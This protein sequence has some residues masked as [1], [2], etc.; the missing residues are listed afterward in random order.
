MQED[1][2]KAAI[3]GVGAWGKNIARELSAISNLVAYSSSGSEETTTWASE[4]LPNAEATTV[5][6]ICADASITAV[7]V[8]TPTDTH[9]AIAHELILAGK[10]I[11]IEKP[12]AKTALEAQSIT[13]E[14]A[15]SNLM[16]ATGYIFLYSPVYR[17]LKSLIG[18][19]KIVK[20]ECL[21]QKYGT[22][23]ESV[24]LNLLTHHLAIAIDLL[25]LPRAIKVEKIGDAG[26][27]IKTALTY[28]GVEFL[29]HIDRESQ[30][31]IH[32]FEITLDSGESF[33][34]NG[35]TLSKRS[36]P[37]DTYITVYE[38]NE[39]PLVLEL[40]SFLDASLG[41]DAYLPSA[42]DFEVKVLTL[43]E[44]AL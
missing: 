4:H 25:G 11:L 7:V 17:E 23:K 13:D 15:K 32:T 8:A 39:Q 2:I 28:E 21:W 41:R 6:A 3:I 5:Q 26:N 10:H 20:V 12:T 9:A 22:F 31:K 18:S 30:E 14:A 35:N 34:W 33:L 44:Q 29:S 19:S 42:G 40:Q 36:D 37:N 24:E 27:E 16:L 43:L 38:N 1:L